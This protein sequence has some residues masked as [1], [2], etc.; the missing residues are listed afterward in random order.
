MSDVTPCISRRQFL[1]HAARA[2]CAATGAAAVLGAGCTDGL[3]V[4]FDAGARPVP[5]QPTNAGATVATATGRDL[6][7]MTHR[8]LASL[9]G[10][11]RMMQPG[12]TVFIKMNL[13]EIGLG[14]DNAMTAGACSKVEVALA[15]AEACLQA[16]ASRVTIGDG[17][18]VYAFDW[19]EVVTLDGS[20][21]AAAEVA[22]LNAIYDDR[23]A[24]ACLNRDSD[25]W[26][27]V[28]SPRTDLGE[29]LVSSLVSRADRIISIPVLKTHRLAQLSSGLKNF[30]GVAPISVYGGGTE[31]T[32]RSALHWAAGGVESCFLDVCTALQPDLTIVDA[33][34]GLE[35]TGP[36]ARPNEGVR[37][38]LRH[39]LGDWLV[40]ASFDPVAADA[41]AARVIGHDPHTVRHLARAYDGGLGQIRNDMITVV[42]PPIADVRVEWRKI[43]DGDVLPFFS[44]YF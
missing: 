12:E 9:G 35:G 37:V 42:G 43:W 32:G 38:D 30:V 29:I 28:P 5:S 41:T 18:Q 4:L 31:D 3:G 40:L 19:E 11:G 17:S 25:A 24:L 16:G 15:A 44:S 23:V 10:M 21:H 13:L 1:R 36:W 8:A 20:S 39:R 22:R 26:D 33:S 6:F 14:R 27:P 2:A 7:E 34:I